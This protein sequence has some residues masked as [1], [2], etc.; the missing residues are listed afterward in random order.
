MAVPRYA[1]AWLLL[2]SFSA[3]DMLAQEWTEAQVIEKF[4]DQSPYTREEQARVDSVR[5]DAAGRVL[6][7]NPTAIA[8]REGAGYAAFFQLE[9]QL[10]VSGR[11]GF[12]KQAGAAAVGVTEAQA[13]M[14][15]WALRSDVRLAFFRLLA[16][17]RRESAL[18]DGMRDINE[19]I[20]VLRARE[21]EGEGSRYDRLRAEREMAE[22]RSQL[23]LAHSDTVQARA[24]LSAFLPAGTAVDRVVGVFDTLAPVPA[25][26]LLVQRALSHRFE[27]IAEQRQ[28]DHFRLEQRAA[29][30]LKIPEPTAIAGLKRGDIAPG[31][32]ESSPAVGITIPLPIFNKG[33]TEVARW[34]A[35]QEG[36]TA[37]RD[38]LERRIHA[39]VTGAAEA[40]R[41]RKSAVEQ[42]RDEVSQ[43]GGDLNR[44]VRV[45]YQEGE[46]GI[47]ELLDS[48]RVTRQALLRLVDLETLAKESQIDLD[49]AVGEE[50]LP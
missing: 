49:R 17:Q 7:P 28:I 31:R 39:E 1:S 18:A 8:T 19:V 4:L 5:A 2:F 27:Y 24:S 41:V 14:T 25:I 33:Q 30:R 20:R 40:L 21:K 34:R 13:A 26:D 38:A 35:E 47:L 48:Y 44:I 32:T 36:A 22:Y 12:L 10:P 42:Y 43:T 11:R 3:A 23:A 16:A 46:V 15:L 9:Q 29:E 50:V 37:R 45:A 6:L